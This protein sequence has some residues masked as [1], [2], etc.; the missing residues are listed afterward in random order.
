MKSDIYLY[1]LN[2]THRSSY[3]MFIRKERKR[4]RISANG[5]FLFKFAHFEYTDGMFPLNFLCG[6]F[7]THH[8]YIICCDILEY[9]VKNMIDC[10]LWHES[11]TVES[12]P[13]LIKV[14]Y[15]KVFFFDENCFW[16]DF[17]TYHEV[18]YMN[19]HNLSFT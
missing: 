10:D 1:I 13:H 19:S 7:N 11:R 3:M 15:L 17:M 14:K 16:F 6:L 8:I 9:Q 4:Q 12:Q 18:N 2:T 5:I